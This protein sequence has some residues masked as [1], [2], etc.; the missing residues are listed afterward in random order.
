VGGGDMST[1]EFA[2][3]SVL[4]HH[5]APSLRVGAFNLRSPKRIQLNFAVESFIDELAASQKLD[6]IAFRIQQLQNTQKVASASPTLDQ[7]NY[8][9]TIAALETVRRAANW[10]T[11]PSPSP[12]RSKSGIVTGR[13]VAAMGNYTNVFGAM[14]GEV[15]VDTKTGRVRV[16]RLIN[17]VDAGLI[18]SPVS[19]RNVVQQGVIFALSRALHEEVKFDRKQIQS[20]DWV[21]YPILR[22]VD[23][24]DQEVVM[25]N[26]PEYWAGG[27]GEGNEIMV[28]AVIAN[29]IFDA[30]GVRIREVPFTPARVRTALKAAG[31]S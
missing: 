1:Y 16:T 30:T 17:A 21:T 27:L 12:A 2:N 19:A 31:I 9:R 7:A 24:P 10:Q 20:H 26:R 5:I 18:L 23:V 4:T 22:F 15:E 13:G 8:T 29:A 14:V 25:I 11:R 3:E 6:P 28:P